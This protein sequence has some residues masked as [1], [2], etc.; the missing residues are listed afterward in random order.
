MFKKI[1]NKTQKKNEEL[2]NLISSKD[3]TEKKAN[4]LLSSGAKLDWLSDSGENYF[5]IAAQKANPIALEWLKNKKLNIDQINSSKLTPLFFAV[6]TG[7]LVAVKFLVDH[8]ANI[9]HTNAFNRTILQEAVISNKSNIISF[10]IQSNI[11][12]NNID[13]KGR[14]VVFDSVANGTKSLVEKI[15]SLKGIDLNLI[16]AKGV[17][18][19]HEKSVYDNAELASVLINNGADP[20]ICD[21][22]GNNFLFYC[23]CGG[24]ENEALID[25]AI[26]LGCDINSKNKEQESILMHTMNAFMECTDKKQKDSILQMAQKLIDIGVDIDSKNNQGESVLTKIVKSADLE[27]LK[28]FLKQTNRDINIQDANGDTALSILALNGENDYDM[29]LTLLEYK[30]DPNIQDASGSTIVEKLI[31]IVLHLKNDKELERDYLYEISEKREYLYVLKEILNRSKVNL[32]C[33]NSKATPIFF[34]VIL[35]NNKKLLSLLKDNGIN[36]NQIGINGENIAFRFIDEVMNIDS[37]EKKREMLDNLETLINSGVDI[38][39]QNNEGKTA[40]H[41]AIL[42]GCVTT[43]RIFLESKVNP[44]ICDHKGRTLAHCCVWESKVEHFKILSQKY[45]N[46][47]NKTDSFGVLPIHYAAFLGY[48]ELVLKMIEAGSF[49]NSAKEI[50]KKMI[51]YL[52]KF[53]DNLDTLEDQT[54]DENEKTNIRLLVN[55]IKKEFNL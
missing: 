8:G 34:D 43:A 52:K 53:V 12:I 33:V 42:K 40:V 21:P 4:E 31:D 44:D 27:A 22:E 51:D 11:K 45:N 46:V 1:L 37:E 48:G 9:N 15:S 39:S 38:N 29:L 19:M 24:I 35:Y 32:D 23:A 41:Y 30:V 3:F 16:D 10:L 55:N 47:L 5:H 18:V 49:I 17:S 36:L 6:E 50:S 14:N 2:C 7:S 20:T 28:F 25:K 54:K 13:S 26:E